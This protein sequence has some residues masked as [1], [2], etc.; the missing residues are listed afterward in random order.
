L[1]ARCCPSP[2]AHGAGG[3]HTGSLLRLRRTKTSEW[4]KKYAWTSHAGG[5]A[6]VYVCLDLTGTE[7][8]AY[9]SLSSGVATKSEAPGRIGKGMSPHIPIQLIG[10]FGVDRRF[11]GQHVGADLVLDAL[12]NAK[13]V[14]ETTG[15]RAVMVR[16]KP[17]AIDF[18]RKLNSSSRS[19]IRF[20][21]FMIKDIKK[22]LNDAGVA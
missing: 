17:G 10:R 20:S 15:V 5:S 3:H 9:Y 1:I 7:A 13:K 12:K 19:P 6:R 4:V 21:S 11:K 18:Y 16:P 14:S 2:A 8:A 22:A